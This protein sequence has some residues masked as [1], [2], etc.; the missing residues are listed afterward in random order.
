MCI[1]IDLDLRLLIITLDL[2]HFNDQWVPFTEVV[3][4]SVCPDTMHSY[5]IKFQ[6]CSV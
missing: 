1:Y 3:V 5:V 6:Y 2:E 4:S